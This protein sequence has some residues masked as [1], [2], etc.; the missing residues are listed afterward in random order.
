MKV[1]WIKLANYRNYSNKYLNFSPNTNILLGKN[2]QGKTNLLEAIYTCAVGKSMRTSKDSDIIKWGEE[3]AKI[4]LEVEKKFSKT[5]IEIYL[6]KSSKKAIK[7]N[8]IP[9][10]RIGEL[11][12]EL[13]CIFFSPDELKLIKES[14][15]DRRRF[16]DIDLSQT[17]KKYFYLL[18]KYE[19]V[20]VSR[21]KI[22][23]EYKDKKYNGSLKDL[24]RMLSVYNQQL[25][26]CA[27]SITLSRNNFL[28]NLAPFAK[29]AHAYLTNNQENLTLKYD[30]SFSLE[31]EI[32]PESQL[33]ELTNTFITLYE[34]NFEKDLKLGYTLI[35]PHR[36]DIKVSLNDIDVRAFGSQGQQRTAALSLKLAELEIIKKETG[37]M[38]IL[39]LDDVLSELDIS[40][41]IRL[42]KFCSLT[43]TFISSTDKPEK[44]SNANIIQI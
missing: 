21:N 9:I 36:D 7:I 3:K 13:R 37:E 17:S 24:K 14:P 10:K 15:E 25:A 34:K 28:I 22:L 11:L 2:A 8:G 12:G 40:R 26:E 44:V 42:L 32:Y 29:K 4:E 20:L 1:N 35:G 6:F 30:A 23:K 38:P 31:N 43:Q 19:K 5:K 18:A 39:I 41:R 33:K 27:A 16:M